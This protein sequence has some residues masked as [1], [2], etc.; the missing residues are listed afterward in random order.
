MIWDRISQNKGDDSE[1]GNSI[2]VHRDYFE[3]LRKPA[4]LW[5]KSHEKRFSKIGGVPDTPKDFK[6]PIWKEQPLSFL[7]QIDLGAIPRDFPRLDFER[8]GYLYFFYDREQ[9]TWGYD[10]KHRGSWQVLYYPG[11][12]EVKLSA[13]PAGQDEA[14]IYPE[15]N[16]SSSTIYTYPHWQDD[17]IFNLIPEDE[18]IDAYNDLCE[19][20][21]GEKPKHHLFGYPWCE[22]GNLMDLECQLVTH[23]IYLGDGEGY[24][25]KEAKKLEKGRE[26]WILLLQL[27]SDDDT[28]M[29]WGDL[30][31]LYFWIRREDLKA[32]RF[33][34]VWMILQCG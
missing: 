3:T 13:V 5:E 19:S 9:S 11:P 15:K 14:F 6:W 27:D 24:Q 17:R 22:Q 23:G 8:S 12:A 21:F 26:E 30:G 29:M 10:P 34:E 20:V 32:M 2:A 25:S 7:C 33:D 1:G 4:V 31:K 18:Q 28:D 16:I